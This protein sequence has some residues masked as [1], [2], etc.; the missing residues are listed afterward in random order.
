MNWNTDNL[1]DSGKIKRYQLEI[2]RKLRRE[3]QP[4][5]VD[6]RWKWTESAVREAA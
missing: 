4:M 1:N 6:E 3:E 2:E 5:G